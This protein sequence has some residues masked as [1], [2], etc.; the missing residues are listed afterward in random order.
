MCS[1]QL[2]Y[3]LHSAHN[4]SNPKLLAQLVEEKR[5]MFSPFSNEFGTC[6][7][8]Y[9]DKCILGLAAAHDGVVVSNDNYRDLI[10]SNKG[11]LTQY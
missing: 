7:E 3:M 10:D 1:N 2:F 8:T 6:T 11:K 9:D 5:A 4:C